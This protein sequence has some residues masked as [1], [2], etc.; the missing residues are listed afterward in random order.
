MLDEV[1]G[2]EIRELFEMTIPV[3]NRSETAA[4]ITTLCRYVLERRALW[5][6]LLAGGAAHSVR[7]EFVRQARDWAARMDEGKTQVPT[8]LGTVCCAG[9][10]IDAL[11]WWLDHGEAYSAEEMAGFI[12]RMII[13]PFVLAR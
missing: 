10:T 7:A 6:T 11:A 12:D 3:F 5:R 8:D 1:A 9:S 4:G 2:E 13:S